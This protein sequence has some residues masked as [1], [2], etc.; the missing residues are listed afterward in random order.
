VQQGEGEFVVLGQDLRVIDVADARE[1][2]VE[3]GFMNIP[4]GAGEEE[5]RRSGEDEYA[6][7]APPNV[8]CVAGVLVALQPT[9]EAAPLA[10]SEVP[11]I[12]P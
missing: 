8:A 1:T 5:G 6:P 3:T 10:T 9:D 4:E 2:A 7:L 11:P 12:P